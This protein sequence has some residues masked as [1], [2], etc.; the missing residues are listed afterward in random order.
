MKI[1]GVLAAAIVLGGVLTAWMDPSSGGLV[2]A[3][4]LALAA[5]SVLVAWLR[6][7]DIPVHW[8]ALIPLGCTAWGLVQIGLAWTVYGFETWNSTTAWLARAAIFWAAYAG[9]Q[10]GAR[11]EQLKSMAMYFGGTFS[12]LALLQWY[13]GGGTVFWLVDTQYEAE[14]AGSFANRDQYAAFIE[15]L[16]PIA[17]A[18]SVGRPR[19]PLV[20]LTCAGVMFASV[21]ASG[22]RA[23][24]IVVC[25]EVL[26][27]VLA[28]CLGS[29]RGY[30]TAG[31][32]AASIL[33][34][35]LIGGWSYVWQRF[36]AGD[37]FAGRREMLRAT[38][39]MIESRPLTGFGLGTWP[40]V[41]PAY[42]VFDP[43]GVY[44]NH[45]HNDWAEWMS[46]GGV[47]L[48]AMLVIFAL[49]FAAR[50]RTSLWSLGILGVLAHALVDFPMQKPAIACAVFFLAGA[51][52]NDRRGS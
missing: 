15:L 33:V 14:V 23:G 31:L 1:T 51:S 11:R 9:F 5:I 21:I 35:T 25:I 22:S 29:R 13:T 45:A 44:M 50:L 32:I 17:L 2:H 19:T 4:A 40:T 24:T 42:A 26:I 30:R 39:S 18:A 27:F 7:S 12:L 6:R 43:P 34:C 16:L 37:P 49:A 3:A 36:A 48:L 52:L 47:P 41:Y 20:P 10:D 28:A 38:L 8:T 46:E